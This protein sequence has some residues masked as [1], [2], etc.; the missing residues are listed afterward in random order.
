MHGPSSGLPRLLLLLPSA[1]SAG[2][3]LEMIDVA[4]PP[5]RRPRPRIDAPP[6]LPRWCHIWTP[7]AAS[8]AA[9]AAATAPLAG[10]CGCGAKLAT[11]EPAV[12]EEVATAMGRTF[13]KPFVCMAR[14]RAAAWHAK[15]PTT[16]GETGSATRRDAAAA[17]RHVI[18]VAAAAERR[19]SL[20]SVRE[21]L[22]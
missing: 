7:Q 19:A 1:E 20:P 3:A 5:P 22:R 9:I 15:L 13:V 6:T 16:G 18:A 4:A 8:R 2:E 14:L 12:P 17:A 11:A 21:R 10:C